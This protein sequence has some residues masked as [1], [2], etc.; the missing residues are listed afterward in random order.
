MQMRDDQQWTDLDNHADTCIVCEETALPT[1]DYELP[2]TISGY[3][4]EVGKRTCKTRM[5]VVAHDDHKGNTYYLHLHQALEIPGMTTNLLC[6]MQLR[7]RG[8][9]VNDEPKHM[10][11]N[12]SEECHAMTIPATNDEPTVVIPLSLR[13]VT[14]CFPTR[15]PSQ[16]E[17]DTSDP[18][19]HVDLT[20]E[21]KEWDSLA[22]DFEQAENRMLDSHGVL[23][24]E[25]Q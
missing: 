14:H 15:K 19:F 11:I 6:P 13:G 4:K 22:R 8:L 16:E 2:V 25:S 20:N 7:D 1:K 17:C 3:Q 21:E 18:S 9:R 5:G 10:A 23:K 24:R 12:P